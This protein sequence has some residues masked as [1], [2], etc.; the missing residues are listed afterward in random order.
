MVLVEIG[1]KQNEEMPSSPSNMETESLQRE[2]RQLSPSITVPN[3]PTATPSLQISTTSISLPLNINATSDPNWQSV[4][5]TIRE[6]NA[7]M[8]NNELMAD[9]HFIVGTPGKICCSYFF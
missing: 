2:M 7:A 6:R 8:F 4:R 5:P 9:I 3:S 1:M